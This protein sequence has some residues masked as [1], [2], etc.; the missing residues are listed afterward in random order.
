M[1][2]DPVNPYTII[3]SLFL[4]AGVATMAWG[5]AII[6]RARR[7][8]AWPATTGTV[9][10]SAVAD[11]DSIPDIRFRY[12]VDGVDHE[13]TYA[14]PAGTQPSQELTATYLAKYPPGAL[15]AVHYDPAQPERATLEPGLGRGDWLIFA[16]GLVGTVFGALF[17]LL[18]GIR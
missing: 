13:G 15:V 12:A 5:W 10:H 6:A 9:T 11:A 8:Q 18:G 7:T 17:L 4:L 14:F 2:S 16:L 1:I 3:L